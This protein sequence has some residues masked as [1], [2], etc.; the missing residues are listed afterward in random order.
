MHRPSRRLQR[1]AQVR[2]V[3]LLVQGQVVHVLLMGLVVHLL[4]LRLEVVLVVLEKGIE[5]K[6]ES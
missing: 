6:I 5:I 2:Q 4:L 1:G 3:L